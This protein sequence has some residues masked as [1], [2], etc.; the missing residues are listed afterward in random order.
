MATALKSFTSGKYHYVFGEVYM[1]NIVDT[2][3]ESMTAEDIQK[4]AHDF[5][6]CGLV[7]ALDTNHDHIW[8][9]AEI[10]SR[11]SP[12]KMIPI[13]PKAHGYMVCV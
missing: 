2:D 4:M 10:V 1:P 7:K 8:N 6:A 11:L 12:A 9:G 13:T 3:G 5:I